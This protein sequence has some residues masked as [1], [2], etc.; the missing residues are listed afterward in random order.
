MA[1]ISAQPVQDWGSLINS[2]GLGQAQTAQANAG[3]AQ[4][5]AN[6]ALIAQQTQGAAIA[7]QKAALGLNLYK[8]ALDSFSQEKADQSATDTTQTPDS[9][10]N[11]F[12]DP[13]KVDTGLR[14]TFFV[15]P[16]GTPQEQK[17]LLMGA[18][19]GDKGLL[20]YAT[21]Q[22]DLGV[23]SRMAVSQKNA[24]DLY[25][26]MT[27][28]TSAPDGLALEALTRIAPG[29]A[30][31]I[32][33]TISDPEK[34]DSAAR[35]YATH[36]AAAVHQYSGRPVEADT[37]GVYRDKVTGNPVPGLPQAAPS[38]EQIAQLVAKAQERIAIPDAEGH[39]HN[40]PLWQVAGASSPEAWALKAA[41][42]G[43][44]P[45]MP[46]PTITGGPKAAAIDAINT[47]AA[48]TK[49][50][51]PQPSSTDPVMDKALKDTSY[52]LPAPKSGLGVSQSP[53]ELEEQKNIVSARRDL[54]AGAQ[55]T[56]RQGAQA[57][58]YLQAAQDILDSKG[59]TTGK[60][61]SV[62][63]QA[64][65]WVPGAQFNA[66]TNYQELAKYLGNAALN[67]AN[68]SGNPNHT[69]GEVEL[70]LHELS[71]DPSMND[72]AVRDMIQKNMA[73]AQYAI[74]SN[75]RARTYLAAGKDPRAFADWNQTYWP[76]QEKVNA[77]PAAKEK[78]APAAKAMPAGAKLN[79]YAT[80]H[81]GGDV[82]KATQYLQSQGYK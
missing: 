64:G 62:L 68:A 61:S 15:N 73:N 51:A 79:A 4:G 44:V 75:R 19:S 57:M 33:Q 3:A 69:E 74:D 30:K 45:G 20:D 65:K 8:Q 58:T 35:E 16:A 59:A 42:A 36:M 11:T 31:Q 55:H 41:Q 60:W 27:A 47:A 76:Q 81:F 22:R 67:S 29:T 72:A 24:N 17:S 25:D 34:E 54:Y 21:Q 5:N 12:Y 50:N 38:R 7:N 28:V 82:A 43:A 1:D 9:G 39:I 77:P 46:G 63:A 66:T 6:A 32:R 37:G 23:Q 13:A 78:A 71:P 49:Q 52:D 80:A 14:N 2:F 56:I 70:Q 26:T 18:M 53:A 10:V 48:A 40:I